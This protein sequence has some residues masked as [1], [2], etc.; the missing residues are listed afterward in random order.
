VNWCKL[1]LYTSG[2]ATH[3]VYMTYLFHCVLCI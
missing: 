3:C 1:D 2:T